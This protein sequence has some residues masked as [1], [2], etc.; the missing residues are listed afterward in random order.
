MCKADHARSMLS[1]DIY[2]VVCILVAHQDSNRVG[3]SAG[4]SCR[5]KWQWEWESARL[6]AG[7]RPAFCAGHRDV[8]KSHQNSLLVRPIH[9]VDVSLVCT[10]WKHGGSG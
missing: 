3:L 10:G 2:L 5:S 4:G 9:I 1:G 6:A 8:K 7:A